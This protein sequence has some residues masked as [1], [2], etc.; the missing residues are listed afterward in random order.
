MCKRLKT[1]DQRIDKCIRELV[2]NLSTSLK[3]DV[4]L[5]GSCC[6]HGKYPM[7]L[8]VRHK[9]KVYDLVSG[10]NIPRR[11]KSYKKD[12]EGYYYIPE[13]IAHYKKK[14]GERLMI[15]KKAFLTGS[16]KK[17]AA[18][19]SNE[20]YVLA[21][22]KKNPN[23]AY[24]VK[25]VQ[26]AVKKCDSHVRAILRKLVKAGLVTQDMPYYIYGKFKVPGAKASMPHKKK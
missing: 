1:S 26:K 4:V 19:P 13:V 14:G 24:K 9:G 6:G 2:S 23:R 15:T 21:F 17:K 5:F 10:V 12:E 11:R 22:L 8:I 3:G 16:W 7:T 20:N 25:D 18:N